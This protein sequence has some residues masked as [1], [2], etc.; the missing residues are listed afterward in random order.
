MVSRH[1]CVVYTEQ[2]V[3]ILNGVSLYIS[4][5]HLGDK[6]P[7]FGSSTRSVLQVSAVLAVCVLGGVQK[8]SAIVPTTT[9]YQF[10]G[11]CGDCV[12]TGTGLLTLQNYT[13]GQPLAWA[14]FVSFTYTS[15]I[16]P[17]PGGITPAVLNGMPQAA[18][19]LSGSIPAVLPAP[20]VVNL[21]WNSSNY[22]LMTNFNSS[23]WWCVGADGCQG[24]WGQPGTWS[25]VGAS[26]APSAAGAPALGV[27][28]LIGLA[29]LLALLGA[30]IL[31]KGLSG[32]AS[33]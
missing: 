17:I 12:G 24:D 10:V 1:Q 13:P 22:V 6:M 32:R 31:R 15:S 4:S 9:T 3:R 33:A 16:N 28:M 5:F 20:A 8:G 19:L 23:G 21:G 11:T 18:P 26:P 29:V 25:L 7:R 27:P 14:N 30:A 2:E